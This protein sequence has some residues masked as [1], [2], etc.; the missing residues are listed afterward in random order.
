[1][2]H[3]LEGVDYVDW[4]NGSLESA[5]V[6]A[7]LV[8]EAVSPRSVI[9]VGCGLGAW[10]VAFQEAG[11]ED[12]L[13]VDAPWVDPATLLVSHERFV[14]ADLREP[15]DAGR[16]FDLALCLEVAQILPP[17]AAEPLVR[18]LVALADVVLFGAA[19]PGQGGIEHRN[20]QWPAYWAERFATSSYAACDPF[21]SRIWREPDVKWWFAQNLL[22]FA[23]PDVVAARPVLEASVSGDGGPLPLVHP[24]CLAEANARAAPHAAATSTE[25]RAHFRLRRRER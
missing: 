16:R 5:R 8:V 19:I 2:E 15:F 21:R 7:P 24:G 25:R 11:V 23:R 18:N 13:G 1:V 22:C 6:V 14:A 20:E 3:E 12:V 9:D 10:L 4:L 17:E